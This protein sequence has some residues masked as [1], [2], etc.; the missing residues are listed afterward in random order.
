M[1]R[2]VMNQIQPATLRN[3]F[4]QQDDQF[5]RAFGLIESGIWEHVT[6]G[7]VVAVTHQEKLVAW[8]SFG[9]FTYDRDSSPVQ[10]DTVFDLASVTKA[11]ATTTM[12]MLLHER[13]KLNL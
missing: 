1:P 9:R 11:V 12:A 2:P 6:P 5:S 8:K 3:A 13:G 7:A 10:P 4:E